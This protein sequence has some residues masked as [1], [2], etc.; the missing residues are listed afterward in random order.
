MTFQG[1]IQEKIQR[2]K[3]CAT[4]WFVDQVNSCLYN[5]EA[6]AQKTLHTNRKITNFHKCNKLGF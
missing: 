1:S 2:E 6:K 5:A 3:K 4:M